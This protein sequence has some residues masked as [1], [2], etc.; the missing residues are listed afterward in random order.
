MEI[1]MKLGNLHNEESPTAS[2]K[3]EES[4]IKHGERKKSRSPQKKKDDKPG[5]YGWGS[6]TG[7]QTGVLMRLD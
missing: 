2:G 5:F 7:F 4:A 1:D 3:T 6:V